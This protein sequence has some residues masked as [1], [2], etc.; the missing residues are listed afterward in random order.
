[1][2]NYTT[3]ME[4]A[5]KGI[6]TPEM[7]AVAAKEYRTEEEDQVIAFEEVGKARHIDGT[8]A[9]HNVHAAQR[10]DDHGADRGNKHDRDTAE[11]DPNKKYNTDQDSN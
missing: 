2:R 7:K 3:Q 10:K 1:M 11:G 9:F 8:H 4:A 6:I 5:R